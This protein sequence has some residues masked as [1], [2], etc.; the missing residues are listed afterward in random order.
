MARIESHGVSAL[1]LLVLIAVF[2]ATPSYAQNFSVLYQFGSKTADAMEPAGIVAQGRDGSLYSTSFD[3]GSNGGPNGHGTVFK[4]TPAGKERVLYSFCSQT[5]CSDGESPQSGLTLRPDGH[6]LGATSTGG[7]QWG[8]IFDI[9][10]AGSLTTLYKF[11]AGKDGGEPEW[12]PILGTDGNFYGT[13][14][15]FGALSGCGTIYGI[16]GG[17]FRLLHQFDGSQGCNPSMLVLGTDGNFYGT[18]AVGGTTGSGVFFRVTLRPGKSTLVTVL[19]NFDGVT[20]ASPEGP[21]VQGSDGNFYGTMV[22]TQNL[23]SQI[24]K[25]TPSGVPTL[26]HTMSQTDGTDPFTGLVLA[27]DGNFYGG[28][29]GGGTNPL[30]SASN[31]CGTLFQVTPAGG[32]SVLYNADGKTAKGPATPTQH[33]NGILYGEPGAGINA[34]TGVFYSWDAGLPAF[35]RTVPDLGKVGSMIGI[36]GQGFT[37]STAVSFNGMPA[38]ASV[39]SGTF[40]RA[41]VPSGATTGFVTVTTSTGTLTSNKHFI[42]TP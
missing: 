39:V 33:T 17:V 31:G 24:F 18:T 8:T 14:F 6:F 5:N 23:P 38:T 15:A 13:T 25:I 27:S 16:V 12:P 19:Y 1:A 10:P 22:E 26:L 32:F 3:G 4:I 37:S 11:T 42:V 9:S 34:R 36:L 40:L 21:L 7:I 20:L 35:V 2:A 41:T 30:C 28:A 29:A